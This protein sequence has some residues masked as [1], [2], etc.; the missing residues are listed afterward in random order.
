MTLEASCP[1]C[2][3]RARRAPARR[4]G[5]TMLS[6]LVLERLRRLARTSGDVRR[7]ASI[8][9]LNEDSG[10]MIKSHYFDCQ[11]SETITTISSKNQICGVCG[12][13][14][15]QTAIVSTNAFGSPDLD[16]RLPEMQR[17]TMPSWVQTCSQCGFCASDIG[18][19]MQGSRDQITQPAYQNQLRNPAF[20]ELANRFLWWG[21][22]AEAERAWT[23]AANASRFTAWVCD[24]AELAEAVDACRRL[25]INRMRVARPHQAPVTDGTVGDSVLRVDLLRRSGQSAGAAKAAP[26]AI[27]EIS[28]RWVC[29]IVDF[30]LSLVR[31]QD[32]AVHRPDEIP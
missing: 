10:G 16:L 13:I 3:K 25:A 5:L 15:E 8:P 19:T 9:S 18:K 14:S 21:L 4:R 11:V 17:S 32:T 23:D 7:I 12:A 1:A 6:M 26:Q 20:L 29:K 31:A 2:S 22:V 24:D 28:N 27:Q 30:E